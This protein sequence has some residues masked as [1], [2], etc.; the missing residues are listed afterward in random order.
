MADK[1]FSWTL[2]MRKLARISQS[3]GFLV[4]QILNASLSAHLNLVEGNA[5]IYPAEQLK[6]FSTS[7]ASVAEALAGLEI[8]VA[9]GRI[10]PQDADPLRL[11]GAEIS[12]MLWGMIVAKQRTLAP[13]PRAPHP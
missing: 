8:L 10:R 4:S 13:R 9:E 11:T 2:G 7:R 5:S 3:D 1:V 6:F 12:R